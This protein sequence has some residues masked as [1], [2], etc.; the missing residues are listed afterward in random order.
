MGLNHDVARDVIVV[1]LGGGRGARLD[2]LTRQRSKPAVPIAGKYRLI[3]VPLGNAI[4]SGM[5]RMFLLTQFNS[6]SLHRHIAETYKFDHFSRGSVQ[7]LAAQQTPGNDSWF[8]GTA[9]AVRQNLRTIRETRGRNVLIL[10][11]DHMYRMD[12]RRLLEEHLARQADVTISVLPCSAAEI[13][14]FG[15]V[16]VERDG[17]VLEFREKPRDAA[18][19]AGM[20]ADPALLAERGVPAGKPYLA[21]MG[22]YLFDK[23]ALLDALDNEMV[24]FG[25]HVIPAAVG[26]KR[27]FAH[28][29]GGYWR[30]IG[31]IRAFFEAHMDLVRADAPFDLYD[32]AWPF[33]THARF[34]PPARIFGTTFERA[35]L[36]E[37][38]RISASRIEEAIVGVRSVVRGATIRRA[39]VMGADPVFPEPR[40]GDPPVGVGE[41]TVIENAIVDKNARIGR[42]C[43]L[44]NERGA[45]ED[46]GPGWAIRDGIVVVAKNAVIPDGTVL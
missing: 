27:V 31:T 44:V 37:G 13:G 14:E 41:G 39:L 45:R 43:R 3:D 26:G 20:E 33:Y 28:F 7:I 1:V 19:R 23:D 5:E 12:Y 38:S 8:Q 35:M 36:A 16:R 9:D 11:G 6:V 4:N 15:A 17:R 21:S 25:H 46:E 24:D 29:F 2:P 22:I 34:L 42:G 30:D 32:P 40:P 18:A 10:A